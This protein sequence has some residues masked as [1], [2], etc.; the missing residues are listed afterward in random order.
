MEKKPSRWFCFPKLEDA[1]KE[2][3][4]RIDELNRDLASKRKRRFSERV[5]ERKVKRVSHGKIKILK[6]IV[7]QRYEK[8]MKKVSPNLGNFSVLFCFRV[9]P[10]FFS[11]DSSRNRSFFAALTRNQ[12]HPPRLQFV[13]TKRVMPFGGTRRG[14]TWSRKRNVFVSK[15][16][17]ESLSILICLCSCQISRPIPKLANE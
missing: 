15:L 3:I 7:C 13:G 11:L 1:F 9:P 6:R 2:K 10:N 17:L 5:K 4:K 8:V 12:C 16:R 14:Q